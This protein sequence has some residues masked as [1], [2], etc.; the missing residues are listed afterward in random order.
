MSSPAEKLILIDGSGLI[1]RGFYAIPPFFKTS[2]GAQA[3]AVFGF[4]SILIS[5]LTIQKP[6]YIAVALDKKGPT[7]RHKEFKEY[8]ATRVKAPQELYDQIPLV[9]EV[10]NAFG[11]PL[12]SAEGFEADD[13]LATIAKRLSDNKN[14]QTFI[15][16]GDFDVFQAIGPNVSILYPAKGFKEAEVWTT[17]DVIKKY[18]LTPEQIP[19]YKG[20]AGDSSDNI[21]GVRGI[22][23]KGAT[24]LLLKYK[25]LENIYEHLGEIGG[26]MHKKL[27]EG[28]DSAFMSKR[29]ATLDSATPIDFDLSACRT[30]NLNISSVQ[31][32]FGKLGFKSL[33][34][35]LTNLFGT[36]CEQEVLF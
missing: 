13:I 2:D 3:N 36:H 32:L 11:I 35:R 19:D 29:L 21:P 17:E 25:S 5:L 33:Q 15:A 1:Y 12:F 26:A 10:I 16:T 18:N 8:K 14:I 9:Q 24:E 34:K 31:N 6:D 7:F 23:D 30:K 4:A 22:G 28:K 20:L 27:E